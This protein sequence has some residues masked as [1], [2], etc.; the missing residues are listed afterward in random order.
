VTDRATI[1]KALQQKRGLLQQAIRNTASGA[2][3]DSGQIANLLHDIDALKRL[4]L[5]E[6]LEPAMSK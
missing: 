3:S 5:E 2:G 6:H 4:L 1:E